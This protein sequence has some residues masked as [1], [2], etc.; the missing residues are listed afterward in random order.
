MGDVALQ[1]VQIDRFYDVQLLVSFK[2]A[3]WNRVFIK[4]LG[5]FSY[6]SAG[7]LLWKYLN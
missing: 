1:W 4:D 3:I 6:G 7:A 5:S 2:Q